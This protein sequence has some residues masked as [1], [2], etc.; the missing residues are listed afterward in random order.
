MKKLLLISLASFVLTLPARAQDSFAMF[1]LQSHLTSAIDAK[2]IRHNA[3]SYAGSPPRLLDRVAAVAPDYPIR[4]RSMRHEGRPIVR[5]T[6]DLKT[7]RVA[8]ATLIRSSGYAALD[9]SAVAALSRWTWRP[10][11]W[12]EIDMPV[13][14]LMGNASAPPPP[15]MSR[16]P[17]S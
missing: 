4:E 13:R 15:G 12:K 16:L 6:L 8:K 3:E 2:G 11:K 1:N 17:R 10:G 5:L 7:G 9:N 14:F